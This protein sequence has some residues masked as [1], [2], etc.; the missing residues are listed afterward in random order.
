MG[1]VLALL[2]SV[3]YGT[4]DFLGGY[5][6]RRVSIGYVL[7]WNQIP[8]LLI[9]GLFTLLTPG[10]M[11]NPADWLW[12]VG[13]GLCISIQLP[14]LYLA[15]GVGP[16][17]V[18]APVTALIG[19]VAPM[20]FGVLVGHESPSPTAY[21]GCLLGALAVAIVSGAEHVSADRDDNRQAGRGLLLATV[22]GTCIAMTYICLKQVSVHAGFVPLFTARFVALGLVGVATLAGQRTMFAARPN[23]AAA[24]LIAL[25]GCL[26][27][28][29]TALFRSALIHRGPLSI[30]AT[31]VSLYPLT[32]VLLATTLLRERLTWQRMVGVLLALSGIALMV[33]G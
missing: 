12:S 6:T 22:A 23:P 10:A 30:V 25:S 16:M 20:I 19:I 14:A 17:A 15:L 1:S 21:A 2:S 13:A 4:A 31:L 28:S 33:R 32:T 7:L 11:T 26:D 24:A 18:V 5:A 8:G 9:T 29:G 27:A 3:C